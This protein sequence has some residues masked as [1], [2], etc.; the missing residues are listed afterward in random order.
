MGGVN[1]MP[2]SYER[3]WGKATGLG[4]TE[5]ALIAGAG[6]V[7]GYKALTNDDEEPEPTGVARPVNQSQKRRIKRQ[8]E[9]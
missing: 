8:I 4:K 6:A 3:A 7:V 2:P 9:K 1:E 5:A